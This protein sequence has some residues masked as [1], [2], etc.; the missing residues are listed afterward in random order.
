MIVAS[1]V[2]ANLK[3]HVLIHYARWLTHSRQGIEL[4]SRSHVPRFTACQCPYYKHQ[5]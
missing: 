4:A 5:I 1:I 2:V 3:G